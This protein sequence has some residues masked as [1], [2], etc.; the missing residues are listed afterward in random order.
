MIIINILSP[1]WTH[2]LTMTVPD[3]LM[4]LFLSIFRHSTLRADFLFRI[5]NLTVTKWILEA[6]RKI[7]PEIIKKY[8]KTSS[9]NLSSKVLAINLATDWSEVMFIHCFIKDHP[10]KAGKEILENQLSILKEKNM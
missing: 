10:C 3:I 6:W 4:I 7:T 5:S 9:L 1:P 8:F 2:K